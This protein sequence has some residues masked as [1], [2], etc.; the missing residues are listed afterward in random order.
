MKTI[1]LRTTASN[2]TKQDERYKW[3]EAQF[4]KRAYFDSRAFWDPEVMWCVDQSYGNI[5]FTFR[6]DGDALWF[7]LRWS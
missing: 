6:K 2:F 5:Y 3:C 4:G 1:N 7:T